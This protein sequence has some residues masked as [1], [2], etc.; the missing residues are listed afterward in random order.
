MIDQDIHR[1]PREP[2]LE[3]RHLIANHLNLR[4]HLEVRE[5]RE[6]LACIQHEF[7]AFH[8][9]VERDA[10][11]ARIAQR[12]QFAS[13][14]VVIHH[15]NAAKPRRVRL[16]RVDETTVVGPVAARRANQ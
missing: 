5:R 16:Q 11:H 9:R 14:D 13:A 3:R 4:E 15:R 10:D 2:G 8:R 1:L 6:K 7:D 12:S